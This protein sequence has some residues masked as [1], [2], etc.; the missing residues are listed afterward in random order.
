[1]SGGHFDYKQHFIEIIADSIEHE[2]EKQGK[3][4]SKEE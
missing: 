2:L 1:M 3:N 4:K